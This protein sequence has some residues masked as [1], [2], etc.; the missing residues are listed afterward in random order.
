MRRKAVR[1]ER[2]N[3][4]I[5]I[6]RKTCTH[7][8][9]CREFFLRLNPRSNFLLKE[10]TFPQCSRIGALVYFFVFPPLKNSSFSLIT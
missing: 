6:I 3:A 4:L 8:F 1:E 9:S 2:K 5:D 7:V 10:L